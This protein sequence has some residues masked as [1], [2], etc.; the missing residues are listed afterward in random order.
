[1]LC[2]VVWINSSLKHFHHISNNLSLKFSVYDHRNNDVYNTNVNHTHNFSQS[3]YI[4]FPKAS[5]DIGNALQ[6]IATK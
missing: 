2:M 6:V 5:T 3:Q 4:N 1:M